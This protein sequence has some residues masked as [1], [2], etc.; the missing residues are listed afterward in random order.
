MSFLLLDLVYD[1]NVPRKPCLIC[2]RQVHGAKGH[3]IKNGNTLPGSPALQAG[4]F[5]RL[6]LV[7]LLLWISSGQ[8]YCEDQKMS[9]TIQEVKAKYT[10]HL[11]AMPGVVSVGIGRNP[12]GTLVIIVGLDGPRPDTV[13]QLPKELEG[14]PVRAEV[15]GPVRAQ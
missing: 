2:G 13:R 15:T 12:D 1:R 6:C 3:N 14:F 11:L 8:V 5:H 7:I 4:S 9:P 10:D